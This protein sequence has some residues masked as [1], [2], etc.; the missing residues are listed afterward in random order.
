MRTVFRG[1][2]FDAICAIQVAVTYLTPC[3]RKRSSMSRVLLWEVD[4]AQS[5]RQIIQII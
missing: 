5:R 1:S 2:N 4:L 3:K